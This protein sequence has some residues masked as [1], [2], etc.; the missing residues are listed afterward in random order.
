MGNHL[1]LSPLRSVQFSS[2]KV[3]HSPYLFVVMFDWEFA[4][5]Q[6]IS[7]DTLQ[8]CAGANNKATAAMGLVRLVRVDAL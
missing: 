6:F 3:Q 7:E 4:D 5:H 8:G 2:F 1:T